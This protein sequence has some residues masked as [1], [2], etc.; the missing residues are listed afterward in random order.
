MNLFTIENLKLELGGREVLNIPDLEISDNKMVALT[1]PNGS[2]KSSLLQILGG[3]T[4][5]HSGNIAYRDQDFFAQTTAGQD[6]IRR[7]LGMILQSPYLFKNTVLGN[8]CYG[9]SR[10]GVPRKEAM[11]KAEV[12]LELVG[13][14]GFG[15]RSHLAL[16][17]GEAQR[18]ALARALVLEPKVLLLDEPFANVDAV[19]RSVIERVLLQENRYQKTSVI[20]TTHDLDQAYRMADTVVTLFEGSIHEG[21]MENLFHGMISLR[22]NG[23]EF[24]TG[25]IRI[26]IPWGNSSALT[27]SIPP[28]SILVSLSPIASSAR[29][30][31]CGRIT[32]VR[33]R[34]STVDVSV[35]VGET[36]V[37]R[38]TQGSYR[39]MGLLLGGEVYLVFKAEAVKLY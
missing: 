18:V 28:E 6:R 35:N 11:E 25:R 7:D 5:P 16:S 32:A 26:E 1:G 17:G 21:S 36:I 14:G 24:D 3:L 30:T 37:A 29:N 9:L 23:A 13:L 34:N 12:A 22:N 33:E 38:I 39:E 2:G 20:F 27:A 15:N 4:E 10:R 8:V 19:S 31:F